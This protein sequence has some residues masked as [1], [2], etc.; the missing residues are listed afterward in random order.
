MA[1]CQSIPGARVGHGFNLHMPA[2][3]S[4]PMESPRKVEYR[5]DEKKNKP[6]PPY[7]IRKYCRM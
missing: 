7:D 6:T 5:A 2:A 4:A 1:C 3:Q